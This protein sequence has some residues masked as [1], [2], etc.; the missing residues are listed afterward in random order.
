[1]APGV[2]ALRAGCALAVAISGCG[3][4]TF[5]VACRE[6]TGPGVCWVFDAGPELALA[7]HV[8]PIVDMAAVHAGAYHD[9]KLIVLCN[10]GG[11][12]EVLY[13]SHAYVLRV[14]DGGILKS[15]RGP[16]GLANPK[17][18]FTNRYAYFETR[19]EWKAFDFVGGRVDDDPPLPPTGRLPRAESYPLLR[20][21]H[22]VETGELGWRYRLGE[23]YR[24]A[25]TARPFGRMFFDLSWGGPDQAAHSVHL[26]HL[27]FRPGGG[28]GF[29]FVDDGKK[30]VFS[31]GWYVICVDVEGILESG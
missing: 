9:G 28:D 27:P 22:N 6:A 4:R 15:I 5:T 31:W 1:M 13:P 7:W 14:E 10:L 11:A 8:F 24:L 3:G 20:E 18:V 2:L 21:A 16:I 26:C 17:V 12:S 29:L 23:D 25:V 19:P 30:L